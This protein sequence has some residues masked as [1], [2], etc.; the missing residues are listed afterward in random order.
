MYLIEENFL[1]KVHK[2]RQ[3][4]APVKFWVDYPPIVEVYLES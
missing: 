2:A 4:L 3:L 1:Y